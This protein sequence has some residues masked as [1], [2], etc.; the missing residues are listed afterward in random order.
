MNSPQ[1]KYLKN[2]VKSKKVWENYTPEYQAGFIFL[3]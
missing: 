2:K 1:N 3:L